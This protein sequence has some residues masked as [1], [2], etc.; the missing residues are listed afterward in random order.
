MDTVDLD[1]IF[2]FAITDLDLPENGLGAFSTIELQV[3]TPPDSSP[4]SPI[5]DVLNDVQ[6]S[7]STAFHP[8]ACWEHFRPDFAL[9]SSDSVTFY[10]HL[11]VMLSGSK[12]S[13][14]SLLPIYL[15]DVPISTLAQSR[16]DLS[17]TAVHVPESSQ[18]LN[19]ILHAIYG[20]SC[21][22]YAPTFET[23]SAAV[24]QLPLYGMDPETYIAIDTPL[25]TLLLSHAP[26]LPINVY[27]LAA[28]HD[29]HHLAVSASPHLLS[30]SLPTLT[31]EMAKEMG[32]K[33]LRKMFFLHMGRVDALKRL[34]LQP[35]PPHA[36]I[37]GCAFADQRTLTRAWALASAYVAWDARPD[38][39]K[40]FLESAL[41]P[42]AEHLTCELCKKS[43]NERIRDLVVNWS[44]VKVPFSFLNILTELMSLQRTI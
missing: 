12:N 23:L 21:A 7:I 33:Y 25:Y 38:I 24:N 11:Q 39:S 40:G 36:P 8:D 5:S 42:L 30:F 18:V 17:N 4:G 9:L 20:L 41:T 2:Q 28:K 10:V 14:R 19:I 3:P 29:L 26:L 13:F 31:D 1:F 43:L 37:R 22:H 16:E 6:V 32:S 15:P 27:T 35:P 34:L 44:I